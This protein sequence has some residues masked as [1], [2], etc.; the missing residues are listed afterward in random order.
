MAYSLKSRG[1][2]RVAEKRIERTLGDESPDGAV[3]NEELLVELQ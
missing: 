1:R 2:K 3:Q